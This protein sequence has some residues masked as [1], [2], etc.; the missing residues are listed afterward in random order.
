MAASGSAALLTA[1]TF[2]GPVWLTFVLVVV[3]G[4]AVIPDSAQFSAI[5]AD[6]APPHLAGSLLTFQT[7]IGFALTIL[8]VQ[9]TPLAA[10]VFGW[11]AVLAALA[12]GPALGVLA[13]LSFRRLTRA[14]GAVAGPTGQDPAG[15]PI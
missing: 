7:A 5:V 1:L 10:A 6:A 11:P 14:G 8:T 13:M 12:I 9:G 15:D 3:W 4:L 2:G